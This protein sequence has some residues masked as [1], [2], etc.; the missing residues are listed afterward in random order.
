MQCQTAK[1]NYVYR[2]LADQPSRTAFTFW[3]NSPYEKRYKVIFWNNDFYA[4]FSHSNGVS[5]RKP[6]LTSQIFIIFK[7][8]QFLDKLPLAAIVNEH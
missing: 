7:Y 8:W 4:N 2:I 6:L 5:N 3:Q 1:R